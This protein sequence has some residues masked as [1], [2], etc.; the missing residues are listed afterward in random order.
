MKPTSEVTVKGHVPYGPGTAQA[1]D[2]GWIRRRL[3]QAKDRR[4]A[5]GG[6]SGTNET[7]DP[8]IEGDQ[9]T[10]TATGP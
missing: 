4:A 2:L 10:G 5:R 1:L 8:E 6:S 9:S 3:A 7:N